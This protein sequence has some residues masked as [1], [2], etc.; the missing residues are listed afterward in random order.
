LDISKI[1][2]LGKE[3]CQTEG[4]AHYKGGGVEPIDLMISKGLAEDFCICNMVKYAT[5]FKNTRNLDDLKK[6]SDYSHILCGIEISKREKCSKCIYVPHNVGDISLFCSDCHNFSKFKPKQIKNQIEQGND[7]KTCR[8]E[9]NSDKEPPCKMCGNSEF[10]NKYWVAKSCS[11]CAN[12]DGAEYCYGCSNETLI[13][14]EPK[15]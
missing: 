7:C 11:N 13:N 10:G 8:Y 2:Q 6:V 12:S 1:R 14:W 3:F 5:R 4:S 15:S 9:L